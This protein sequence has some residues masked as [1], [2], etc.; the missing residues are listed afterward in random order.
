MNNLAIKT[1]EPKRRTPNT[2][3]ATAAGAGAGIGSKYVLPTKNE[4]SSFFNKKNIDTFV[5]SAA[6]NA[7]ANSRSSLKFAGIGA[8]LATGASFIAK[9]LNKKNENEENIKKEYSKY[10]AILDAADYACEI[11]WYND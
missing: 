2:F 7:R 5:S 8:V 4:F 9:A 3:L 6:T 1:T 11:M 10:Q